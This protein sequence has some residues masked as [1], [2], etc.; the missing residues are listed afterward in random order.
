MLVKQ[1]AV[2]LENRSGSLVEAISV[3]EEEGLKLISSCVTSTMEFGV[4]YLILDDPERGRRVLRDQG[5][6]CRIS[7]VAVV[8]VD[9]NEGISSLLKRLNEEGV[10]VEYLY[11]FSQRPSGKTWMAFRC[12]DT[13]QAVK[14]IQGLQGVQAEDK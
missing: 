7:D 10:N 8:L 12:N 2:F 9:E 13:E 3:L 1:L 14:K 11:T 4:L 5:V 6:T